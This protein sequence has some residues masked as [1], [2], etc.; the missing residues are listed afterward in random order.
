VYGPATSV[1]INANGS[2]EALIQKIAGTDA[3]VT[4]R[5]RFPVSGA[6]KAKS[7]GVILCRLGTVDHPGLGAIAMNAAPAPNAAR[8]VIGKGIV[9][10]CKSALKH[11]RVPLYE[12]PR[13]RSMARADCAE[14]K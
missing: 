4:A 10:P 3:N 8:R 14:T 9:V 1:A 2:V 6:T 7:L 12:C 13:S 5:T 11:M